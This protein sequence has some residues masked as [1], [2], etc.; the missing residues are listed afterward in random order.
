MSSSFNRWFVH[1][2]FRFGLGTLVLVGFLYYSQK[3]NLQSSFQWVLDTANLEHQLMDLNY[4]IQLKDQP[5]KV[6]S[7]IS[8]LQEKA[9][10]NPRQVT[11]LKQI[12][13]LFEK[14]IKLNTDSEFSLTLRQTQAHKLDEQIY[15]LIREKLVEEDQLLHERKSLSKSSIEL[16]DFPIAIDGLFALIS[17]KT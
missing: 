1:Y 9:Q 7:K 10:D 8:V 5:T 13:E 11:R 16:I 12:Q 14:K 15:M 3:Q 2:G 17:S 4:A 6:L